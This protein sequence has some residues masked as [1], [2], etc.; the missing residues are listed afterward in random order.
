A[1]ERL[2]AQGVD[3][4][5]FDLQEIAADTEDLRTALGIDQWNVLALG[6][7]SRIALEYLRHFPNHTRA[8]VLDS[9]EWPGVDPSIESVAATRHA[10]AELVAAC[11]LDAA[12]RGLAPNLERDL[13]TVTR[14]LEAEPYVADF[15]DKGGVR[16][17]AGWFL[18]W[19]RGGVFAGGVS[20]SGEGGGCGSCAPRKRSSRT[21]SPIS[22][23]APT[24]SSGCR[25]R[26]W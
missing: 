20:W 22:P 21:R 4:S 23:A 1:H 15:G 17:A 24:R 13:E 10:I 16:F 12:C 25:R 18:V 5:A 2:V 3:L 8:A 6:T 26:G 19:L 14:R 7:T 11:R 9:P